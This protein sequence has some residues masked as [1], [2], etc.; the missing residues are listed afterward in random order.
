MK[1]NKGLKTF[2]LSGMATAFSLFQA[3]GQ[4]V[5]RSSANKPQKQPAPSALILISDMSNGSEEDY[6]EKWKSHFSRLGFYLDHQG[7]DVKRVGTGHDYLKLQDNPEIDSAL[8][9]IGHNKTDDLIYITAHGSVSDKG[10]H[11]IDLGDEVTRIS[12]NGTRVIDKDT[13]SVDLAKGVIQKASEQDHA[14]NLILDSCKGNQLLLDIHKKKLNLPPLTAIMVLSNPKDVT[15]SGTV[16]S[17]ILDMGLHSGMKDLKKLH[18]VYNGRIFDDTGNSGGNYIHGPSGSTLLK[19]DKDGSAY[20]LSP[21]K[22]FQDRVGKGLSQK[23]KKKILA[24]FTRFYEFDTHHFKNSIPVFKR[25]IDEVSETLKNTDSFEGASR[26][27]Q[28]R[29]IG[30]L[31]HLEEKTSLADY[32]TFVAVNDMRIE[33]RVFSQQQNREMKK[34]APLI[35]SP[36]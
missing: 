32:V 10:Y 17:A 30:Y 18:H 3:N 2:L 23:E 20:V 21:Y 6:Q 8:F 12:S 36:R 26:D 7:F 29:A 34:P 25:N 31:A 33:S 13:T 28:I 5:E 16:A 24:N 1:M 22:S 14:L 9:A 27:K 4:D 19:T 15:F 35:N 11:T